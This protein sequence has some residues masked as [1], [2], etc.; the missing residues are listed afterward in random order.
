MDGNIEGKD[1]EAFFLEELL[2]QN[3]F[4]EKIA[5]N[6]SLTVIVVFKDQSLD[7]YKNHKALSKQNWPDT[8]QPWECDVQP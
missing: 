5:S 3:F 2:I 1:Y 8:F 7:E 6:I 4:H